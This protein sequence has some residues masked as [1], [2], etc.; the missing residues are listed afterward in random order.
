[1]Y[2]QVFIFTGQKLIKF[3]HSFKFAELKMRKRSE[4]TFHSDI[5]Q[6]KLITHARAILEIKLLLIFEL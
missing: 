1:M 2:K 6:Q 5:L 3:S 4:S